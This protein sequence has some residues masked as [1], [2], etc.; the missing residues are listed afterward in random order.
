MSFLKNSSKFTKSVLASIPSTTAMTAFS[1]GLSKA[2]NKQFREP[3]ILDYLVH[4][5][6]LV[7]ITRN[8]K[9]ADKRTGFLL[10]YLV[11]I[12]Y[13]AGYEYLWKPLIKMPTVARGATYGVFAGL[14]GALVWESIIRMRGEP[15]RLDKA[16]Y[17][18][19]LVLAHIIFGATTALI[20]ESMSK[21]TA[22]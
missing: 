17:Y 2:I 8:Y 1:Y 3:E 19:Q 7:K 6:P 9:W 21:K 5:Q 18:S 14:A 16:A 22:E 11:G 13:S 4:Q 20:S 10:H 12:G 15:P